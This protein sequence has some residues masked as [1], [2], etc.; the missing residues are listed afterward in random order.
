MN[1]DVKSQIISRI[2]MCYNVVVFQLQHKLKCIFW[3]LPFSNA[4]FIS[5]VLTHL[6]LYISGVFEVVL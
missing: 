5:K 6:I 4:I 3:L 1:Q 2:Y